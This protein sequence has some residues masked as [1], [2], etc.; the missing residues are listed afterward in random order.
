VIPVPFEDGHADQI[1]GWHYE[2]PYDFY[3][4][5]SDPVDAQLLYDAGARHLYRAVVDD[6]GELIGWWYL[7]PDGDEV[8]IG[9]GL[10]PDLTGRGLGRAFVE[11]ELEYARREWSP[12]RFRLYVA[13][14]NERARKVYEQ[15]G[16]VEVARH[17]RTFD[18][19]GEV[20]FI[21][22]D[23]PGVI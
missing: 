11:Q 9:L 15:L 14:F 7:V 19:F 6:A 1:A 10:R 20:E 17:S 18:V 2:P 8:E 3:D 12:A 13:T 21:R 4:A 16:F 23:R 5:A 22:M